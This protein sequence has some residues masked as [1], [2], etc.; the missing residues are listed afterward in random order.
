M[1]THPIWNLFIPHYLRMVFI[2]Q[3]RLK[4]QMKHISLLYWLITHWQFPFPEYHNNIFAIR[5]RWLNK[6][7]PA[8]NQ[9]AIDIS[10]FELTSDYYDSQEVYNALVDYLENLLS[11]DLVPAG[12]G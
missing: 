4:A 9:G 10:S 7:L 8:I 11:N 6:Y 12:Q 2:I 1:N 5:N 3:R